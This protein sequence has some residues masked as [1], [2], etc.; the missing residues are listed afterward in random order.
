MSGERQPG[1]REPAPGELALVQAFL[2]THYNLDA[3]GGDVFR[4]GRALQAWLVRHRLIDPGVWVSQADLRRV[5]EVR[6]ALRDFIAGRGHASLAVMLEVR[7]E[8]DGPLLEPKD[9][10]TVD[11]AIAALLAIVATE[12]LGERWSRVKVC[13]GEDCGWAFYDHSR[14]RTGRWCSM[15]VCGGRAKARAHYKRRRGA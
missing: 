13:P 7:I 5:I 11:G 10:G 3:G 8:R 2:N 6:E 14:N 1:G 4:D 9:G 15:D 12:M